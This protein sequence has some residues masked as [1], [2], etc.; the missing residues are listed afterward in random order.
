MNAVDASIQR[1]AIGANVTV[2]MGE[3]RISRLVRSGYSYLSS[4]DPRT[5]FGLGEA[6][7]VDRIEVRWPDGHIEI[8]AGVKSDQIITLKKGESKSINL[9]LHKTEEI[10]IT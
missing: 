2:I 9:D 7:T 3:K 8:F 10:K 5:H 1:D 6:T 4:S